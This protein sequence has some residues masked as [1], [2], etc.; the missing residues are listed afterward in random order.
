[1]K[2]NRFELKLLSGK[3]RCWVQEYYDIRQWRKLGARPCVNG[4]AL[5]IGCG[6]GNGIKLAMSKFG[7][8]TVDAFDIDD[9]MLDISRRAT[10][11][12]GGVKITNNS[13]TEIAAPSDTYDIVFDYQVLHHIVDWQSALNEVHRVMKPN[14]QLM[15]AESLPG[16]IENSW[17][18]RR[19]N[20]PR[21]NRFTV[22]QLQDQL[23]ATGFVLS[24]SRIIGD[25]FIWLIATKR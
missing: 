23:L 2:L 1:M 20:H 9:R 10:A 25:H 18:G 8:A 3:L 16:L 17:I 22:S 7:V 6:Q 24:K 4:I 21:S 5:D 14:A 12:L 15:I 19:M 11:H 13:A